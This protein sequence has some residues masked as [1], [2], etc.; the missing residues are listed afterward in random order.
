MEIHEKVDKSPVEV[1]SAHAVDGGLVLN[2]GE[3]SVEFFSDV[4]TFVAHAT[5]WAIKMC[6]DAG[7]EKVDFSRASFIYHLSLDG[8]VV[9]CNIRDG[10]RQILH[11]ARICC[12]QIR[13]LVPQKGC[14]GVGGS[15]RGA[16]TVGEMLELEQSNSES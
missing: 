6:A 4:G 15:A 10:Q 1:W 9:K 12:R 3:N 7:H 16:S 13:G 14:A 2:G 5:A 8:L 11:L